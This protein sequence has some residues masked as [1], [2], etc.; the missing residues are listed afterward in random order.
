M[1]P[2]T[3]STNA[4]GAG[5][6]PPP[7]PRRL[8]VSKSPKRGELTRSQLCVGTPMKVVTRSR[9]ISSS[10]FSAFQRY[11]ITSFD[12]ETMQLSSTGTQPVTWNSGTIRMN[13]SG[14]GSGAGEPGG[15]AASART[16]STAARLPNAITDET[17]APLVETAPFG[18]PVVPEVYRIVASSSQPTSTA[19]IAGPATTTS[20]HWSTSSAEG[21]LGADFEHADPKSPARFDPPCDPLDV[22][23]QQRRAAVGEGVVDLVFDP[24]R[25]ER[26]RDTADRDD[27]EH[28]HDPLG[29]VAHADGNPV[30][31]LNAVPVDEGVG[32]RVD[33]GEDVI[34]R[35]ALVLED[36]EDVIASRTGDVEQ[37]AQVGWRQFEPTRAVLVLEDLEG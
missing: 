18:R 32:E 27:G 7:T 11:I 13:A 1:L 15:N 21:E 22:R 20:F 9:S 10:A 12:L 33:L 5:A 2:A 16:A 34:E 28:R 23:D 36:D 4:V 30:A 31:L 37:R 3:R 35:Q 24:Q 19:G 8:D 26:H 14:P 29:I 25:V 17:I 6:P